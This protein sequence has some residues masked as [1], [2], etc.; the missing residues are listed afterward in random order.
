MGRVSCFIGE[1]WTVGLF[2]INTGKIRTYLLSDDGKE[3]TCTAS[4]GEIPA[5]C[6]HPVPSLL[7]RLMFILKQRKNTGSAYQFIFLLFF[8]G[9]KYLCRML[10][11]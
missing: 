7:S 11:L 8:D 5:F 10:F 4:G 3:V 1:I 2:L 9:T 6:L